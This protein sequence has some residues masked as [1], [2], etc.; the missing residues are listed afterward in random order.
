MPARVLPSV[1]ATARC[2]SRA[3]RATIS[4]GWLA[5]VRNVK[6]VVT[7]SS[8]Y[9]G[10]AGGRGDGVRAGRVRL[11]VAHGWGLALGL[12]TSGMAHA[13]S[14]CTNH[15]SVSSS[16]YTHSHRP[17]SPCTLK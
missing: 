7:A 14:P 1:I 8:A 10:D 3:A 6:L 17:P 12:G 13:H 9:A 16:R 11:A 4:S 15:R 5:P 2:P